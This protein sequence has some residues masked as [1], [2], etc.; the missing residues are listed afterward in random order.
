MDWQRYGKL[1]SETIRSFVDFVRNHRREA[2]LTELEGNL[3]FVGYSVRDWFPDLLKEDLQSLYLRKILP[4]LC[5]LVGST[6]VAVG[7]WRIWRW[8]N[9]PPLPEVRDRPNEIKGPMYRR[10]VESGISDIDAASIAAKARGRHCIGSIDHPEW[11][12][13]HDGQ[14][15]AGYDHREDIYYQESGA[16][17][18]KGLI[19]G[20]LIIAVIIVGA[21]NADLVAYWPI[22]IQ[23]K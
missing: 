13:P 6:A 14:M 5:S 17:N 11:V 20:I 9:P 4:G 2:S 15:A 12:A 1:E 16:I 22:G 8:V 19:C 3:F 7:A 21:A 10:L 18:V 23:I